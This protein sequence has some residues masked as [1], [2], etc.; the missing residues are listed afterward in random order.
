MN[1]RGKILLVQKLIL[2]HYLFLI[3][4]EIQNEFP[5]KFE[6]T[7]IF[8]R[9]FFIRRYRIESKPA[10]VLSS[11]ICQWEAETIEHYIRECPVLS[12]TRLRIFSLCNLKEVFVA[13]F[14][15]VARADCDQCRNLCE[16]ILV[17]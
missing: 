13:M 9:D 15:I 4:L 12:R 3:S 11:T 14:P 2:G 10:N 8:Y 16:N 17:Q 6:N 5:E 7:R 1:F